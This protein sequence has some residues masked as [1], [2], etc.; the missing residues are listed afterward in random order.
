[1]PKSTSE[2]HLA[3]RY[4]T[5]FLLAHSQSSEAAGRFRDRI[6]KIW[7]SADL[8]DTTGALHDFEAGD[9]CQ[10]SSLFALYMP[11]L[12]SWECPEQRSLEYSVGIRSVEGPAIHNGKFE[13]Q[14][15]SK[16]PAIV[17]VSS[18]EPT[19]MKILSL[20]GYD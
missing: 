9:L 19:L 13:Q 12:K 2:G 17:R 10:Y 18:L 1:M 4:P 16:A 8:A 7:S 11:Q 20:T 15:C 3:E 5:G 14:H 6:A